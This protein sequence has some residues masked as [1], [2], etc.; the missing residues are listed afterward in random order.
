VCLNVFR[1][2]FFLWKVFFFI[3]I[4]I[5]PSFHLCI[6]VSLFCSLLYLFVIFFSGYLAIL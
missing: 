5:S 4:I 3:S 6:L 1:F 2:F